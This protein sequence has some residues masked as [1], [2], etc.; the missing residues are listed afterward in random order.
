MLDRVERI[1]RAPAGRLAGWALLALHLSRIPPPGARSHHRRVVA[2]VLDD[3]AGRY[4]GQVFA[5]AGGDIALLF[6]PNG[7]VTA[8][9]DVLARLFRAD[10]P[11]AATLYSLWPLPEAGAPMLA[12]VMA[13]VREGD[14]TAPVPEP[15]SSTTAIAAMDGIVQTGM[16]SDLM[17]RQTAVLLRPGRSVAVVP[18][19]REVA[20]ATAVLEARIAGS[21]ATADPFLFAHLAVRLDHRMLHDLRHDI[22]AGGLLSMGLGSASLHINMT[23]AGILSQGFADFAA[24]S[25]KAIA[26]GLRIG[27]EV[28]FVEAFADI[29]SF[30]VA[31]ERLRLA[32]LHLVLDGISHQA[33]AVTCPGVLAPSLVKLTWSPA[34]Q[35][36]GPALGAAVARLGPDRIV[37]HRSDGEAAIAWGM[38]HGISRFQGRY[39]DTMLAAERLRSCVSASHCTLRQ[40]RERASATGAAGRVGCRNPRLL[41]LGAPVPVADPRQGT[42]ATSAAGSAA[43]AAAWATA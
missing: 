13:G 36:A 31:R 22:P 9:L 12:F 28:P 6:R 37:L 23:L 35:D 39:I 16:L 7:S 17:H 42:G 40:C 38:A 4:E 30:I 25:P 18:L 21:H 19:F 3:A 1:L 15:L 41:D 43:R 34:M 27:V 11:D 29:K 32:G 2:A 10:V 20:I 14:R 8:L 26:A 33:L 5:L 24:A